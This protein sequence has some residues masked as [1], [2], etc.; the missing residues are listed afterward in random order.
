M[1]ADLSN[2]AHAHPVTRLKATHG[3]GERLRRELAAW[4]DAA[5]LEQVRAARRMNPPATWTEIGRALG[6]THTQASRRFRNRV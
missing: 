5:E 6:V 3:I 1:D 4:I 2:L